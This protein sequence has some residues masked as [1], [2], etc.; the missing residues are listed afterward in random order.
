[1]NSDFTIY[2]LPLTLSLY[3]NEILRKHG[4]IPEKPP[5]PTPLIE[6]A[7]SVARGLAHTNR[8]EGKNLDELDELE[9]EEDHDFLEQYR[10][11]PKTN[12]R[13]RL[14]AQC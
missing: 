6:E 1:M 3:R 8:L 4:I 13:Y 10:Y 7:L 9:D 2:G 5:S 12:L 14:T 11:G